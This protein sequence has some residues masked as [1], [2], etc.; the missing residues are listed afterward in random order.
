MKKTS[1]FLAAFAIIV[2]VYYGNFSAS[3]PLPEAVSPFPG[4][5]SSTEPLV[6]Q[7]TYAWGQ[8]QELFNNCKLYWDREDAPCNLDDIKEKPYYY[9]DVPSDRDPEEGR[10]E[11]NLVSGDSEYFE[12]TARHEKSHIIWTIDENGETTCSLGNADACWNASHFSRKEVMDEV[13]SVFGD[14]VPDDA[15]SIE[16]KGTAEDPYVEFK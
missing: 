16:F 14:D 4:P 2:G 12:A 9:Q 10:V 13:H 3:K 11:I 15:R 5:S 7:E 8:L 6:W 1:N